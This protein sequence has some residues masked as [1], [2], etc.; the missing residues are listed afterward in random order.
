M[1]WIKLFTERKVA[2]ICLT[3][4]GLVAMGLGYNHAIVN[5]IAGFIGGILVGIKQSGEAEK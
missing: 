1:N 3:V 5:V 2:M 4:L